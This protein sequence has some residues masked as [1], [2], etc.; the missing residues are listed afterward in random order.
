M[1]R[2][3]L[4]CLLIITGSLILAQT[5]DWLWVNRAGGGHTE[6]FNVDTGKSIAIDNQ[7]NNYL[8]GE[9]YGTGQFGI[10]TLISNG[11]R[12][13]FI[14]KLD[15]RGNWLWAISFGGVADDSGWNIAVDDSC[16]IYVTGFFTGIVNFATAQLSSNDYC[17]VFVCKLN[18]NGNLLWV[19]QTEA[20]DS[21]V[22][23][24]VT[25][26]NA[27]N[28]YVSGDFKGVANFGTLSPLDDEGMGK[29]FIAKLNANGN[30][31][32]VKQT[33]GMNSSSVASDIVLDSTGYLYLTGC[34][35]GSADFGTTHL[36]SSSMI[37][38][39]AKM[40]C[41]GN[42]LWVRT[43]D[44]IYP[45]IGYSINLDIFSNIFLTGMFMNIITFCEFSV[46]SNGR[47]DIYVAKMDTSGNFHWLVNA[48]GPYWDSGKGVSVDNFGNIYVTGYFSGSASLG[49]IILP[50][51]GSDDVLVAKLS[52]NGNWIWAKG[53][54]G[55]GYDIPYGIASDNTGNVC[56]TG[57]FNSAA[58]LGP[59]SLIV[60]GTG[61]IFIAKLNTGEVSVDDD[62][63]PNNSSLSFLSNA[64]PNPLHRGAIAQIEIE[65]PE[66]VAGTLSVFNLKGQC[67][68]AYFLRPGSHQISFDSKNLAPGIYFYQL[69]TSYGII[70]KKLVIF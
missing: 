11:L 21:S 45:N 69:H 48:G 52:S 36:S 4:T 29:L 2:L 7:G 22:G 40:D 42:W 26:D 61:S 9:F 5:P 25:V 53:I 62:I 64:Y 35:Q 30:W 31:L 17:D 3:I 56:I 57:Y 10:T 37:T 18:T 59:D 67:I 34:F 8:T 12:D 19:A 60:N 38:F 43:T 13:I 70:S 63:M 1:K 58:S 33:N 65:N 27:H 24:S 50:T 23:M 14:A 32:W 46:V 28:V 6:D 20:T 15:S 44:G 68:K 16:N 41:N 51:I 39:I 54:G 55:S 66:R 47:Y 49:T